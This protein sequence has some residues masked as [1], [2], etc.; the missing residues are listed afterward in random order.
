VWSPDGGPCADLRGRFEAR[1][2]AYLT[3]LSSN[4]VEFKSDPLKYGTAWQ[5]GCLR[6]PHSAAPAPKPISSFA[7]QDAAG[8]AVR[9]HL[10]LWTEDPR[11]RAG[12]Y[13]PWDVED[14]REAIATLTVHTDATDFL[15]H[16]WLKSEPP[17]ADTTNGLSFDKLFLLA[18]QMGVVDRAS[19]R[20]KVRDVLS[21]AAVG[22]PDDNP[23]RTF[24]ADVAESIADLVDDGGKSDGAAKTMQAV[25]LLAGVKVED[26][27][28]PI[29]EPDVGAWQHVME[30]GEYVKF[31]QNAIDWDNFT[32]FLYPYFWDSVWNEYPNCSSHTPTPCIVNSC[33]AAR[34]A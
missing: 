2:L 24:E 4:D 21:G 28:Q 29:T 33:G 11:L 6:S 34:S 31:V 5:R 32:V 18:R 25:T 26:T 16:I 10:T 14:V 23:Q 3:M 12:S 30:Y 22:L 13:E 20:R 7:D 8:D 1:R 27:E 17:P 15:D 9:N 19:V